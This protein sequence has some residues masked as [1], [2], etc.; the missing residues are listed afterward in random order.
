MQDMPGR[1]QG[2]KLLAQRVKDARWDGRHQ[3]ATAHGAVA[4]S[5][6]W[7]SCLPSPIG[8]AERRERTYWRPLLVTVRVAQQ[9]LSAGLASRRSS[10]SCCPQFGRK[11]LG[12]TL[13]SS[14]QGCAGS[15]CL[16]RRRERADVIGALG[17][18]AVDEKVGV[19]P[20]PEAS[21]LSTSRSIRPVY[22]RSARS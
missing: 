8:R 18:A 15:C 7:P 20:T 22:R 19:P 5:R 14:G 6:P 16:H 10:S 17:P 3:R 13:A 11:E 1:Q 12:G 4:P 9:R 2:Q 21:A